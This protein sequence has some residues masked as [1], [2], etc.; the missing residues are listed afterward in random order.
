M[1]ENLALALFDI[2][3]FLFSLDQNLVS[4]SDLPSVEDTDISPQ[5]RCL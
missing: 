4:I 1:L 3:S 5:F 2:S